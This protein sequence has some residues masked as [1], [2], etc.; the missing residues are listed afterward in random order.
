MWKKRRTGFYLVNH[1]G[2]LADK[3]DGNYKERVPHPLSASSV[4][5]ATYTTSSTQLDASAASLYLSSDNLIN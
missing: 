5:L 2:Q 3:D 4:S 1:T